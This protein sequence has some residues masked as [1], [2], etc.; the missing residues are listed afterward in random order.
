MTRRSYLQYVLADGKW[1]IV[2]LF[3]RCV[4]RN[5]LPT[6][7]SWSRISLE[8]FQRFSM[9]NSRG[10]ILEWKFFLYDIHT[11]V[12]LLRIFSEKRWV[13]IDELFIYMYISSSCS[14]VFQNIKNFLAAAK[15]NA[16]EVKNHC[17]FRKILLII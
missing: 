14:I 7:L 3:H 15:C 9:N 4:F 17:H 5:G 8:I 12:N 6:V 2:R 13:L 10:W 11:F 1:Q 16:R